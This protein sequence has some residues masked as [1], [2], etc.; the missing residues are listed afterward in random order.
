M[1]IIP[2]AAAPAPAPSPAPAAA[3]HG[4]EY[5]PLSSTI[6]IYLG[7]LLF[8]C[9]A[10]Y[11]IGGYQAMKVLPFELPLLTEPITSPF[12]LAVSFGSFLFLMF[13]SVHR[14]LKGGPLLAAAFGVIGLAL[15]WLY[16]VNVR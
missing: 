10:L 7:W 15:A 1:D 4:D 5:H 3:A 12:I 16:T 11:L 9:G 6:A 13:A 14:A 8:W 2:P